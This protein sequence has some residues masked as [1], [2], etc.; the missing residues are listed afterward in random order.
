MGNLASKFGGG[1]PKSKLCIHYCFSLFLSI[2]L[3]CGWCNLLYVASHNSEMFVMAYLLR[4][5]ILYALAWSWKSD[6]ILFVCSEIYPCTLI[7]S[8]G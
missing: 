3:S 1:S 6:E 8:V 5:M 2:V 7:M 4:L